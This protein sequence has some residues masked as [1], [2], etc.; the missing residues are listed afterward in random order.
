MEKMKAIEILKEEYKDIVISPNSSGC[1]T[2]GL[3]DNEDYF[4]WKVWLV[5]PRDS[6][7]RG[8]LFILKIIFPENYPNSAPDIIFLTPIYHLNVNPYKNENEGH[9][10]LGYVNL[11]FNKKWNPEIKIKELLI[12]LYPLFYLTNIELPYGM[13]IAVEYKFKRALYE[14]KAKYFT[15][16]YANPINTIKIYDKSWDFSYDDSDFIPN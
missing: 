14:E 9:E 7:Y 5:G 4:K 1:F 11:G 12:Q 15:K 16:K 8:G 2:V 6:P 13:D 3:L 10:R